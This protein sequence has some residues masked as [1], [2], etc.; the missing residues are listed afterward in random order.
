MVQYRRT[1]GN[2]LRCGDTNRHYGWCIGSWQTGNCCMVTRQLEE[3][4]TVDEDLSYNSSVYAYGDNFLGYLRFLI[5][6]T[7]GTF[8][9]GWGH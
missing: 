1:H 5:E 6:G 9:I 4:T 7:L 8:D 2:L 3:S